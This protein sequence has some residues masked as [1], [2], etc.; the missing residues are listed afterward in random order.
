MI[1]HYSTNSKDSIMDSILPIEVLGYMADSFLDESN[2]AIF[3]CACKS[4]RDCTGKVNRAL[5]KI[6]F[7]DI[8]ES[9]VPNSHTKHI[10]V[11]DRVDKHVYRVSLFVDDDMD[12]EMESDWIVRRAKDGS[13][14]HGS[15]AFLPKRRKLRS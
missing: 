12:V 5:F 14:V 1:V 13:Y 10:R 7:G 11:L 15:L 2:R 8:L 4:F 9:C 6:G 3:K